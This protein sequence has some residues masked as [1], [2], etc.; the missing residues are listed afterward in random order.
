[1]N[2]KIYEEDVICYT[3]LCLDC[4]MN[5]HICIGICMRKGKKPIT[6]C[7]YYTVGE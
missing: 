1:M 2:F 3:C 4:I 6:K 7:K 5:C